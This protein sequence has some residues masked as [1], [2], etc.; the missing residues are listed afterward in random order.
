M[1]REAVNS[2]CLFGLTM[3][4]IVI[5]LGMYIFYRHME[6][7]FRWE[8]A[9]MDFEVERLQGEADYSGFPKIVPST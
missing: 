6:M 7:R 2:I 9:K 4:P 5:V 3:A 8:G 1:N